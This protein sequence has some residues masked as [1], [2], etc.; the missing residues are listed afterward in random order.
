MLTRS[1]FRCI[2]LLVAFLAVSGIGHA[3][4]QPPASA[5]QTPAEPAVAPEAI[6][7]LEKMGG[8]LRTLKTFTL[9]ADTTL[10][11]VLADTG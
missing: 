10:D 5:P 8:F 3:Q 11:E 2:V 9:R 1:G 4:Q 6:A 7:A